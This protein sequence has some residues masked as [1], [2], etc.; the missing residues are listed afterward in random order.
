MSPSQ[1]HIILRWLEGEALSAEEQS[2]LEEM[3]AEAAKYSEVLAKVD[4][5]LSR[6]ELNGG[7]WDDVVKRAE[8]PLRKRFMYRMA[9]LA[10]SLAFILAVNFSLRQYQNAG[11]KVVAP[12][13]TTLQWIHDNSGAMVELS[14]GAEI[15][16]LNQ[17]QLKLSG[18]ALFEVP[19][20][21]ETPLI[22][23]ASGVQIKVLGTKFEVEQSTDSVHI[24]LYE[25]LLNIAFGQNTRVLKSGSYVTFYLK[26]NRFGQGPLPTEASGVL[27]FKDQK[28]ASIVQQIGSH[29][30]VL[31]QLAEVE[32]ARKYTLNIPIDNLE[33]SLEL[34]SE[35]TSLQVIKKNDTTYELK[36]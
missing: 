33:R 11:Q 25:G 20:Q 23:Y 24:G 16:T 17:H 26:E 8:R 29:Y 22:I 9:A 27:Q 36:P 10:A 12:S 4:D 15:R 34:I 30:G 6:A 14:P 5:E 32:K 13:E 21:K 35:L 3:N 31:L 2:L 1:K 19:R 18:N 28:L 7:N